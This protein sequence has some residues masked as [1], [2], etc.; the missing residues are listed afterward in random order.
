MEDL[1]LWYVRRGRRRYW[2]SEADADKQAAY[3]TLHEVL[4]TLAKLLAPFV[5]FLAEALYQ[6]LVRSVDLRAPVSVHLCDMPRADASAIDRDLEAATEQARRLVSLGR[7]A[8]GEAGLRVRQPLASATMV[9]RSGSVDR[10]AELVEHVREELNVK[11][12]RFAGSPAALGRLEVRPRFDLL[13]PRFAGRLPVIVGA[14][15][16]HGQSL[17][18]RTPEGEPYRLRLPDGEEVVLER[19]EV[20]VRMHWRP[21]LAGAGDGGNWVALETALS[22]DLIREGMARE[23]V[24]QVQQMRKEA[25]LAIADRITLYYEGDDAVADLLRAHREYV[26]REVL[27][28]DARSGIPADDR[29]HRKAVRLDGREVRLGIAPARTGPDGR[30][31]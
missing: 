27:A 10:F 17:V 5:P 13:G 8:R 24:H 18:E 12:I 11:E 21:G 7:A 4:V 15:R 26:L 1:S 6:N 25:G 3:Q 9:D 16:E 28:R 14:L 19:S 2:K 30:R 20:D 23:L 31:R 22:E 29:V